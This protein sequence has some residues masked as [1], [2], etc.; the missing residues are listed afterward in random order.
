VIELTV[1]EEGTPSAEI[2]EGS[3]PED[4]TLLEGHALTLALDALLPE[5]SV[6]E[7]ASWELDDAAVKRALSL[8]LDA[9]LFPEPKRE[10]PSGGGGGERGQGRRGFGRRGS[11]AA[12]LLSGVE[13]TGK[14][15][16]V[17][18]A[19]DHEGES[20]AQVKLELK[21][22]GEIPEPPE[23]GG[24]G[25][26]FALELGALAGTA[27]LEGTIQVELEGE[28]FISLARRAPVALELSGQ[29]DTENH[30]ERE[31]RDGAIIESHSTQ[32]GELSLAVVVT[33]E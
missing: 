15:T 13:W 21:A 11:S 9:K 24:G 16:L 32:S 29:I 6:E 2:V 3:A 26:G 1:D 23:R 22:E 31:G 17:S 20:C 5:G 30:T 18:A 12:R 19:T 14:A 33:E 25:R 4:E 8:A 28:L 10:E 7:D 27:A